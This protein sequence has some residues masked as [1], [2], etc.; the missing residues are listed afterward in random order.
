VI[1]LDTT[2]LVYAVGADHPL[3]EPCRRILQAHSDGTVE[4]TTTVEVIQEFTHVRARRQ[5]RADAVYLARRYATAFA[6]LTTRP[7]DLDLGLTLYE[8]HPELG[9]FDAMLAAV[10]LNHQADALVSA[11]QA[12]RALTQLPWI[13]PATPAI[14]RILGL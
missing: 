1:L 5:T 9:A 4:A 6:L 14:N 8:G 12:F 11:D 13:D 7:D 2:I 10:A 3:R